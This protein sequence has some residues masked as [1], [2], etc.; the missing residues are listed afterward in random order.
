MDK[1][2]F[3]SRLIDWDEFQLEDASHWNDLPDPIR[4][5]VTIIGFER[6]VGGDDSW[7][8]PVHAQYEVSADKPLSF[9][10]RLSP[11]KAMD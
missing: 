10:F 8:E 4:S 5:Y 11:G 9:S 1:G 2:Q 3:Q 6:G 7:G